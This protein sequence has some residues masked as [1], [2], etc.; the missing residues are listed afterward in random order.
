MSEEEL[1]GQ[2][3][4][5]GSEQDKPVEGTA[6]QGATYDGPIEKFKGKT[7]AEIAQAYSEVET[8]V[9]KKDSELKS[10]REKLQAYEQWY[11]NQQR[12]AMQQPPQ[13]Q[14]QGQPQYQA[15]EAAPDIYDNPMGFVQH[16]ARPMVNQATEEASYKAAMM[17]APVMKNQARQDYPELFE[18]IDV[19]TLERI[20]Y[21]GVRS[22]SIHYSALADENAWKMAAGQMKLD[23]QGYKFGTSTQPTNPVHGE[24]PVGGPSED[25]PQ[26][27][28]REQRDMAE[29][30]G[31][32]PK[33]AQELWDA[34]QKKDKERRQ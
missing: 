33:K 8:L 1:E 30:L 29:A 11:Q 15:P 4:E 21:D 14:P 9:G 28:G 25:E 20:M 23:Q 6:P 34:R 2:Q 10:D 18:G 27:M 16:A 17:V 26:P 32:D 13:K 12:Q 3:P 31:K 24:K 19:P 5:A 7:A 22:G